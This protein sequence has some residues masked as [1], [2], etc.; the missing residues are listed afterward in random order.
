LASLI[1]S[2]GIG[3]PTSQYNGLPIS[4]QNQPV[5]EVSMARPDINHS[6]GIYDK[7][8]ASSLENDLD[9]NV[10]LNIAFCES[11]LRQF[12]DDG[13]ALRGTHN[14]LDVGIFQIN[15]KY[16]LETSRRLGYDIYTTEGNI[17]YAIWLM[18]KEGTQ[19]WVWSRDAC[20]SKKLA[21]K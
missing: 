18:K 21:A 10:M 16:H 15:E 8:I 19:P 13:T 11:S 4:N 7:I 14:A 20:W 1:I 2:T 5:I 3:Q 12:N 9:P 17:D 6:A